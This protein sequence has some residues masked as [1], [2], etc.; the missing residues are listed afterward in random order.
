MEA[1][2][3]CIIILG[4]IVTPLLYIYD[5]YNEI[6]EHRRKKKEKAFAEAERIIA[7]YDRR[8]ME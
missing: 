3:I 5:S 1:F 4:V 7:E 2:G 6:K 8:E